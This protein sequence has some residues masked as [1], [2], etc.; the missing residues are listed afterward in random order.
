M[1]ILLLVGYFHRT[2]LKR[3]I[4]NIEQ[5]MG[6][7]IAGLEIVSLI[8]EKGNVT[9]PQPIGSLNRWIYLV[10]KQLAESTCF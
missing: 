4:P 7:D 6:L 9:F 5:L 3:S 8:P 2:A 1:K 10:F